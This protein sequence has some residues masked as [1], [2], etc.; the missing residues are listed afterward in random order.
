[1]TLETM[2]EIQ[3]FEYGEVETS[4][5][6]SRDPVLGAVID[7]IGHLHRPVTPDLFTALVNSIVGQQ[8][9]AKA[10]VTVWSR[11]EERFGPIT[12]DNMYSTSEDDLQR[13]GM[14]MRKA[15]YIRE[16][17]GA[18]ARGDLKLENLNAMSD[19]EVCRCL[20]QIKGVGVWTAEMLMTFSMQRPNIMSIDDL[21]ILR[22][23]RML[24]G[25][26][27]IT[28]T[29][30]M[31]YK[32]RYSPYATVASLY[33]WAVAGGA[34]ADLEDPAQRKSATKKKESSRTPKR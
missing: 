24:Y 17:A 5:L 29:L 20:C 26:K 32:R 10:L 34:C 8:I 13:C 12:P 14:T 4:W 19:N 30:F 25:H 6:K 1:M 9:S 15:T 27:K 23:L 33:L 31:K 18:V 22:G 2:A 21:A 7:R 11:M 3:Y 16:V 28:P